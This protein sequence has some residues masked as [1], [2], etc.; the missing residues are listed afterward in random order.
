VQA[1]VPGIGL[2]APQ[3]PPGAPPALLGAVPPPPPPGGPAF[4]NVGTLNQLLAQIMSGPNPPNP[5]V[6]ALFVNQLTPTGNP[7]GPS[8]PAA[9]AP[10]APAT[11]V[12]ST[13]FQPQPTITPP[14]YTYPPQT[15]DPTRQ[16][17]ASPSL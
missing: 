3:S 6:L 5:Q 2:E 4:G 15:Y 7:P 1:V 17:Q 8:Q 10:P 16:T 14:T 9:V 11:P 12:V 13:S